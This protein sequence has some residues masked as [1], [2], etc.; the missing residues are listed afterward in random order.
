MADVEA[1]YVGVLRLTLRIP[2]ARSLKDRRRAIVALR[3]R[4]RHRFPVSFAE[5]GSGDHPTRQVVGVAMIGNSGRLT[6]SIIDQVVE[7][8]RSGRGLLV[9]QVDEE[10][11][12]WHPVQRDWASLLDLDVGHE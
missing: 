5:I 10:I 1:P 11:F 8:A 4:V 12:K 9:E 2:A 3:D 7:V 6:Q